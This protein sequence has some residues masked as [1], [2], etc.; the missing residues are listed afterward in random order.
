MS[1][2]YVVSSGCYSDYSISGVF[3]TKEKSEQWARACGHDI[4][5]K[6]YGGG[7]IEEY[8][9][10]EGLIEI[11]RGLLP[12][13]V[14][15]QKN[16]DVLEVTQHGFPSIIE[17]IASW[18]TYDGF[19]GARPPRQNVYVWARDRDHAIKVANERRI[20]ALAR[21]VPTNGPAYL[22]PSGEVK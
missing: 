21:N 17:P 10:D 8:E 16:G 9:L 13:R 19:N 15:I 22:A 14:D 18:S 3:S 5:D 7:R 6:E 11:D 4:T 1:K 12:F 2:I 20:D